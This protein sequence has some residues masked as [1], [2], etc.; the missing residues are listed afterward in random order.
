MS[1]KATKLAAAADEARAKALAAEKEVN[2]ARAKDIAS[3]A[4]RARR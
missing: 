4:G 2:E 1:Q 3:E